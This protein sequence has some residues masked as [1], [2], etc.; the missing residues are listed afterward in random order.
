[1]IKYTSIC[2]YLLLVCNKLMGQVAYLNETITKFPT[3]EL[4]LSFYFDFYY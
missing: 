4:T 2:V 3:I 1:M